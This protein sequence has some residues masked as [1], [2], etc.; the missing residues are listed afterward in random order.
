MPFTGRTVIAVNVGG[1][2]IPVFFSLYLMGYAA[3]DVWQIALGIA[4]VTA[5]SYLMSRPLAGVGI[6]MPM[7]V[8]PIT[9]AIVAIVIGGDQSAPLAYIAGTL[10]VLVGADLLRF[11]DVS[12]LGVP[13]ASIGGAGTFDGIFITGLIAVLLA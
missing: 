10:G 6:G 2:V 11:R 13:L 7:F 1:G 8:A 5:V 4:A 12:K 3:L 9:A